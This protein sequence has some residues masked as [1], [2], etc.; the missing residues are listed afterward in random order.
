MNSPP[1]P[2]PARLVRDIVCAGDAATLEAAFR[3]RLQE[4][5]AALAAARERHQRADDELGRGVDQVRQGREGG[6]GDAAVWAAGRRSTPSPQP[7]VRWHFTQLVT[8]ADAA[9]PLPLHP[10]L[11][12]TAMLSAHSEGLRLHQEGARRADA[13]ARELA[14]EACGRVGG[15]GLLARIHGGCGRPTATQR[16]LLASPP[17]RRPLSRCTCSPPLMPFT[18]TAGARLCQYCGTGRR[19]QPPGAAAAAADR[20][21]GTAGWQRVGA[22]VAWR[23][24]RRGVWVLLPFDATPCWVA[25]AVTKRGCGSSRPS[26]RIWGPGSPPCVRCAL[27]S[28]VAACTCMTCA[29]Q[30]ACLPDPTL[31]PAPSPSLPFLA[32]RSATGSLLPRRVRRSCALRSA[33]CWSGE[34]SSGRC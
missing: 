19:A 34:S 26:L 30:P 12:A 21:G 13:R 29:R 3:A 6:V 14:A 9:R 5:Q 18:H 4:A 31:Q 22:W 7:V 28:G 2:Q 27:R 11:Q 17:P 32:T 8:A 24:W 33:S 16:V 15:G 25:C 1:P 10:R 20:A 23:V